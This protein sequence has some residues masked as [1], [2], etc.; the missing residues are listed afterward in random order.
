MSEAALEDANKGYYLEKDDTVNNDPHGEIFDFNLN[1]VY[2]EPT[3]G[4]YYYINLTGFSLDPNG[5]ELKLVWKNPGGSDDNIANGADVI[6]DRIEWGNHKNNISTT[7]PPDDREYDNTTLLDCPGSLISGQ[8]FRRNPN[9]TDTDNCQ[10]DFD[11]LPRTPR[12]AGI[13]PPKSKPGAP[14]QLRVHRGP[15]N[16]IGGPDDL[17]LSWISPTWNWDNLTK[18]IVYYDTDISNGFQ[19]TSFRIVDPNSTFEGD[20]DWCLLPGYHLDGNDYAFIIHTTGDTVASYENMTGTNVGYKYGI[21]LTSAINRI[22]VSIPY[23]SDYDFAS[24]ITTDSFPDGEAVTAVERWNYTKQD[25][26][27]RLWFGMW[28]NDFDIEPGDAIHLS[29][30][31]LGSALPYTWKIVGAHDPDF[32]FELIENSGPLTDYKMLSLPYHRTY[33]MASDITAEFPDKTKIS[34]VGH[35]NYTIPKWEARRYAVVGWFDDFSILPSPTDVVYFY[36]TSPASY[37]WTPQ[38]EA[39]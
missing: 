6:V 24:D 28:V 13:P 17:V 4:N 5:D 2:V 37:Y 31:P 27:S 23:H 26:D 11:P 39:F 16:A 18:N 19:Y 9:G 1:S 7:N 8:S 35:Y 12:P 32:Q 33:Q 30:N 21:T 25:Y 10:S 15:W 38:V 36:V 34:V 22:W 14:T 3:V 29:I 20:A